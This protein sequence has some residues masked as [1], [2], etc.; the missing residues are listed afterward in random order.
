[1]DHN[2]ESFT[3]Y[4]RKMCNRVDRRKLFKQIPKGFSQVTSRIGL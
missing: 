2:L 4:A 3:M 1:M